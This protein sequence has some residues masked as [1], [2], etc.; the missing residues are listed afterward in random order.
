MSESIST[1]TIFGQRYQV[2]REI[3]RGGMAT[4]YAA[5]DLP[6]DRL[7]VRALPQ[8]RSATTCA[9]AHCPRQGTIS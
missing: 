1:D 6:H 8:A 9:P 7:V 3:G 4:V 5:R 2:E